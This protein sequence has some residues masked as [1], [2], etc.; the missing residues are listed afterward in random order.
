MKN[1][2]GQELSEP[3]SRLVDCYRMLHM[4]VDMHGDDLPPFARRN[5]TK[6]I[7]ALWQVMNGLDMDPDQL[8]ELGA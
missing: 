2:L 8:Y 1:M 3:E 4:T 7:A 5:A 6:A